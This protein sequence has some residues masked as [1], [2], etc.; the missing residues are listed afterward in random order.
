MSGPAQVMV[1]CAFLA[2]CALPPQNRT[3][4]DVEG[5]RA[6]C[7]SPDSGLLGFGTISRMPPREGLW[8]QQ[9][10]LGIVGGKLS[11]YVVEARGNV[12]PTIPVDTLALTPGRDSIFFSYH[13]QG[14]RYSFWL[15]ISCGDLTGMAKLFERPDHP[16]DLMPFKADRS[17]LVSQ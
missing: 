15:H 10:V 16:G 5:P 8:G 7:F 2:S 12:G 13:S 14:N 4:S 9:F 1:A 3:R 11:A 6:V 17:T